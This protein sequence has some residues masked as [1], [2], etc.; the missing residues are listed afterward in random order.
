MTPPYKSTFF[1]SPPIHCWSVRISLELLPVPSSEGA[2]RYREPGTGPTVFINDGIAV[3]ITHPGNAF[4]AEDTFN[5]AL[6]RM[7]SLAIPIQIEH[8]LI[9]PAS[10]DQAD[11]HEE[12]IRS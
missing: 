1:I 10:G 11:L 2:L 5:T 7:V 12:A 9:D 6:I 3:F 8:G 4:T